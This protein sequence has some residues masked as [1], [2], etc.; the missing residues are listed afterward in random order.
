[1]N[2]RENDARHWPLMAEEAV[3]VAQQMKDPHT[4]GIML[5]VAAGFDRRAEQAARHAKVIAQTL[6]SRKQKWGSINRWARPA[7]R[8]LWWRQTMGEQ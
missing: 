4:K 7:R 3:A 8:K 1:M 2:S 5:D 6:P